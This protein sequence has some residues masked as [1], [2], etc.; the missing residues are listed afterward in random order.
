MK[1]LSNKLCPVRPVTPIHFL[2]S[3]D[4]IINIEKSNPARVKLI[5]LKLTIIPCHVRSRSV[6]GSNWSPFTSMLPFQFPL[7]RHEIIWY[8]LHVSDTTDNMNHVYNPKNWAQF[9]MGGIIESLK[10]GEATLWRKLQ[11][12]KNKQNNSIFLMK[13]YRDF[14][15]Y[16]SLFFPQRVVGHYP[17]S[18]KTN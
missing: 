14:R 6:K 11:I 7:L 12:E 8:Y 5:C 3:A 4:F 16:V 15:V 1:N 10:S 17:S 18:P 13:K 9:R 2:K